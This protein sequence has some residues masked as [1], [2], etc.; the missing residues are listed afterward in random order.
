VLSRPDH[1]ISKSL[2]RLAASLS[3]E[4]KDGKSATKAG[5]TPIDAEQ[6]RRVFGRRKK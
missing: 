5:G 1:P 6:K 3:A 2:I 4:P